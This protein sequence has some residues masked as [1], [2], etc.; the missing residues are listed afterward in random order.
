MSVMPASLLKGE[1][2]GCKNAHQLKFEALNL[3]MRLWKQYTQRVRSLVLQYYKI[4]TC[5]Y[6]GTFAQM[7]LLS[8]KDLQLNEGDKVNKICFVP[9]AEMLRACKLEHEQVLP[10]NLGQPRYN[11]ML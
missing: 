9:S 6:F 8:A 2:D 1:Q 4:T 3:F 10:A 7:R 11:I 5:F